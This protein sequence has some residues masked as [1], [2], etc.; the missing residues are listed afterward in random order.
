MYY[1]IFMFKD[2][3]LGSFWVVGC[4]VFTSLSRARLDSTRLDPRDDDDD[5]DDDDKKAFIR[6]SRARG[7]FAS[8]RSSS[9]GKQ[10]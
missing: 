10:K 4:R 8:P 2:F 7:A 5:D 1:C 3:K 9:R 6:R